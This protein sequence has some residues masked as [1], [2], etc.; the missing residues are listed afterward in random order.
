M[1]ERESERALVRL[2]QLATEECAAVAAGDVEAICRISSLLPDA[3]EMAVAGQYGPETRLAERVQAI[4]TAHR[5]AESCLSTRLMET[6]EALRQLTGGKRTMSG[7]SHPPKAVR[8][9]R[10]EG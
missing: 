4:Q 3:T 2:E 7:Y 8:T 5:A 10:G 6:R 1:T 9:L